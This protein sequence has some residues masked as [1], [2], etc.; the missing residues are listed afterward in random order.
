MPDQADALLPSEVQSGDPLL[1]IR[2]EGG[3]AWTV[4]T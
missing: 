4:D 3:L 1:H 2:N